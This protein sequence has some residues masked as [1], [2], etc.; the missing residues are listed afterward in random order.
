M[1]VAVDGGERVVGVRYPEVLIPEVEVVLKEQKLNDRLARVQAVS[2]LLF[3]I[4]Y[5]ECVTCH[6]QELNKATNGL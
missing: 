3:L 2:D 1:R 6:F 5:R 4:G